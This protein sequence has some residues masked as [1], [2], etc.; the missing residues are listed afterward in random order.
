MNILFRE[1]AQNIYIYPALETDADPF[2]KNVDIIKMNPLPIKAIVTD[3][4]FAKI[5][6]SMVGI[7]TD[8]A[9]EI[10][11]E[12]KYLPLLKLS[13]KIKIDNDY[14]EGWRQNGRLQFRKEG[15]Y[16]R[17]YIYIKKV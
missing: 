1:H 12:A 7:E 4:A 16:I 11:I 3:L 2:E 8:R 15:S 9:K 14:Y 5:Q 6:W 17:A 10:I 13:Y